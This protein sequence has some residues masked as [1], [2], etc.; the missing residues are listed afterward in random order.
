MLA[1][2]ER[3]RPFLRH[4]DLREKE[5]GGRRAKS[6]RA[7][8]KNKKKRIH[9]EAGEAD[10]ACKGTPSKKG[11]LQAYKRRKGAPWGSGAKR[12]ESRKEEGVAIAPSWLGGGGDLFSIG[13]RI[14]RGSCQSDFLSHGRFAAHFEK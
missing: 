5:E 6:N 4:G 3:A 7:S 14:E 10:R 12:T 2:A 8:D 1:H 9:P 11:V 13:R